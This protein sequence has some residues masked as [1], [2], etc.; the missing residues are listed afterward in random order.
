MATCH[1]GDSRKNPPENSNFLIDKFLQHVLSCLSLWFWWYSIELVA[2]TDGQTHPTRE[3]TACPQLIGR[4][5]SDSLT[6]HQSE[7]VESL[8]NSQPLTPLLER[9]VA[10]GVCGGLLMSHVFDCVMRTNRPSARSHLP[11][12]ADRSWDLP[13]ILLSIFDSSSEQSS[14][15]H[16][17]L[18]DAADVNARAT[19]TPLGSFD[20]WFHKI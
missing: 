4:N 1:K 3:P 14:L 6:H 5:V 15:V 11:V 16:E 17:L 8:E 9:S 2:V 12:M 20:R 7:Q 19:E 10:P 18:W 13:T